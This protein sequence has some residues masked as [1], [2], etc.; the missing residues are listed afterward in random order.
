M[1]TVRSDELYRT[2]P[3]RAM[4][5]EL[6]WLPSVSVVPLGALADAELAALLAGQHGAPVPRAVVRAIARRSGG[7]PFF[8][9]QLWV[10]Q[11]DQQAGG[12]PVE[13]ADVLLHR[14]DQLGPHAH[15][16]LRAASLARGRIEHDLLVEVLDRDEEALTTGVRECTDAQLFE[17][18]PDG[19]AYI[20][21]H[22]LLAEAI[23][24]D[25]VPAERRALHARYADVLA[26][27]APAAVVARHSLGAGDLA[28]AFAWS[29]DAAQEASAVAAPHD[30]LAQ[31]ERVLE[32]WPHATIGDQARVGGKHEVALAASRA[33]NQSGDP[34]R[35]AA[36]ARTALGEAMTPR[37]RALARLALA[38]LLTPLV[39]GRQ[40]EEIGVAELALQDAEDSADPALV[41]DARFVLARAYLLGGRFA[42]A[43]RLADGAASSGDD[44]VAL[45]ARATAYLA[46]CQL[47]DVDPAVAT[48]LA[49]DARTCPD[50]ETALWVLTRIAD[51]WWPTDPARAEPIARAAYAC[52]TEQG[53]RSSVRGMWARETL[54]LCQ[55]LTGRWDA[56]E[57]RMTTDPLA[58]NDATAG[59]VALECEVDIARDRLDRARRRLDLAAKVT[60]DVLNQLFA[61]TATADLNLAAG[62]PAA[63]A[64]CT[65]EALADPP[66][67]TGFV[68]FEAILAARGMMA[69]A[70]AHDDG[71]Q[72]D[73][74][75]AVL[76]AADRV[77][78]RAER[79]PDPRLTAIPLSAI[80]AHRSRLDGGDPE[81][82]RAAITLRHGQP[83][84]IAKCR[85]F[86]AQALSASGATA[87]TAAAKAELDLA[88]ATFRELG[89]SRFLASADSLRTSR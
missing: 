48:S 44:A 14:V 49:E 68:D 81:L 76:A 15:R 31:W 61:A 83:F 26:G 35:A 20:F 19:S 53:V 38:P 51:W 56:I 77:L 66:P 45:G 87:D 75:P 28:D 13:V 40:D 11:A 52:A 79:E 2:H 50:A 46:R 78:A 80:K 21:R 62:D 27:T 42:D 73:A 72:L 74:A 39:T 12:P 64:A 86:L 89:A 60:T 71:T 70:E 82:W 1:A 32:L 57:D 7:N 4:L 36:L 84:E 23:A 25:L 55:W 18:T 65:L 29:V 54:T 69:L 9:E 58:V 24:T 88:A 41:A 5:A 17:P 59:I 3:L 34:R 10:A 85:F 47:G 30:A 8:A 16:V 67:Q 22:T 33:A 63:A 37:D 43:A 6:G